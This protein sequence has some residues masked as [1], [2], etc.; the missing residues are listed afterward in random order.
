MKPTLR[1]PLLFLFSLLLT[2]CSGDSET[3]EQQLKRLVA[4]AELA[5]ESRD[6]SASMAF[7]DPDYLDL[8][9]RG[10]PQIRGLL[11]GY[12]LRHP[13]IHILAKVDRIE[14]IGEREA[15]LVVLAGLAG[16]TAEAET[17]LGQWRGRLMRLD[18]RF[19]LNQAGEWLL[20]KADWRQAQREDF[21]E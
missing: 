17:P 10:W 9:G 19:R 20:M 13:S 4:E 6:L 3:P 21:V 8:Q 11:A 16:S 7:V 5:V 2:S 14:L 18:L 15:E 12:L 1:A